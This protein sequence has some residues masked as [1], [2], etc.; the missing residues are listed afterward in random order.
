MPER[1]PVGESFNS[2][3]P[4][5]L[6][7]PPT[8]IGRPPVAPRV[9]TLP[10][11]ELSWEN[12][13]RLCLKVASIIDG[14]E[15]PRLFGER[16]ESQGGIDFWGWIA[17]EPAVYQA[18]KL[19]AEPKGG[20][21][22]SAFLDFQ[23]R[24]QE[25]GSKS[26]TLCTARSAANTSL[27]RALGRLRSE[28]P[29]YQLDVY[30]EHRLT[31]ILRLAPDLVFQFFGPGWPES[32]C[33]MK[34]SFLESGPNQPAPVE[35]T[36]AALIGP[37]RSLGLADQLE[38]AEQRADKAQAA[39]T[40]GH[41]ANRLREHAFGGHAARFEERQASALV[42]AGQLEDAFSIWLD[43]AIRDIEGGSSVIAPGSMHRM[44][45]SVGQ[46]SRELQL[47]H[48]AVVGRQLW[49]DQSQAGL[50][51]MLSAFEELAEMRSTAAGFVGLWVA[52]CA[53]TDQK[54]E[55]VGGIAE[56]LERSA[57]GLD[58]MSFTRLRLVVAEQR[59]DWPDLVRLAETGQLGAIE[60]GLVLSRYGRWLAWNG[61]P[62][63]ARDAYRKAI[64]ML[65]RAELLG[66]ASEAL[67]AI[68]AVL[69][70]YG[71]VEE[72][73]E[74]QA[75]ARAFDGQHLLI[76]GDALPSALE[77][78]RTSKLPDAHDRL[79]EYLRQVTLSGHLWPEFHGR[80][81][82]G[83]V[84]AR[85]NE[86]EVAIGNYVLAGER[87]SAERLAEAAQARIPLDFERLSRAPWALATQLAVLS[88]N[89]DLVPDGEARAVFPALLRYRLGV[90]Q[91][92][93]GPR[94]S[95]EADNALA[96]LSF[97]LARD[98]VETLLDVYEP[99][100]EREA[101]QYRPSDRSMV[102]ILVAA[103]R[104][105]PDLSGRAF[106]DLLACLGQS[107]IGA[108]AINVVAG[109][110]A[111][112]SELRRPLVA[113]AETGNREAIAAL[114]FAGIRHRLVREQGLQRYRRVMGVRPP[115]P[116]EPIAMI[117]TFE[118]DAV[119]IRQLS[120]RQRE[121][122]ARKL[123]AVANS[124]A[125]FEPHRASALG[126][127]LNLAPALDR[128]ARSALLPLVLEAPDDRNARQPLGEILA[129]A[130]HALSRFRIDLGEDDSALDRLSV[131]GSFSTDADSG[132]A[133][134]ESPEGETDG[135]CILSVEKR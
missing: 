101:T 48:Q 72:M 39:V 130:S 23:K 8:P 27:Q 14:L 91:S 68:A 120:S 100:I 5:H 53:L 65:L 38:E 41:I 75:M 102:Q 112:R 35:L 87:D 86:H 60:G 47:R 3:L 133:V 114:A 124:R 94:V 99:L 131:A 132:E 29:D 108:E 31:E 125:Y 28:Y 80:E 67:S 20:L 46:V 24:G 49:R 98:Q 127:L 61:Q 115:V 40:Y 32:F 81:L 50:D 30:D 37:I 90:R 59:E 26:F 118:I 71:P 103:Y 58:R 113:L 78:L 84:L 69:S 97:Q 13:E 83:D 79:R 73:S 63:E 17:R 96:A 92:P 111:E 117:E 93:F 4:N 128:D 85:A 123:M 19:E 109:F 21:L 106:A 64:P 16:G 105:H 36:E 51:Q 129:S 34:P 54:L 1:R 10:F 110:V 82:M 122:L 55:I 126:G 11:L 134:T 62:E 33:G 95:T 2:R 57:Q 89:G 9:Q 116:G 66:D 22:K 45:E 88:A 25:L 18:R 44:R 15:D 74:T 12:F 119:F 77:A 43:I 52:E 7:I 121:R 70:R 42:E 135:S 6:W 76:S 56:Q 104:L 107:N